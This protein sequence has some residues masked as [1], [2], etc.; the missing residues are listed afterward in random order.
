LTAPSLRHRFH[1]AGS[2]LEQF[3]WFQS[4]RYRHFYHHGHLRQNMSLGGI[5][6][7]FDLLFGTY[8]AVEAPNE[9]GAVPRRRELK[10][11]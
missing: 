1:I 10:P 9:R 7:T 4:R 6:P 3:E 2:W 8:V 5:D 11:D